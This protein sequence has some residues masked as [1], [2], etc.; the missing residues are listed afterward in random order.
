VTVRW[1]NGTFEALKE[2]VLLKGK[3]GE[4]GERRPFHEK[5]LMG[6]ILE[7][8][9]QDKEKSYKAKGKTLGEGEDN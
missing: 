1:N 6:A 8:G 7:I 9:E 4:W 3:W 2:T 5:N